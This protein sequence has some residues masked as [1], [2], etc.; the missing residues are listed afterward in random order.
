MVILY[1]ENYFKRLWCV[2][3]L[4]TLCAL[5]NSSIVDK[6]VILPVSVSC[7]FISDIKKFDVRNAEAWEPNDRIRL[8]EV[9]SALGV[10]EFNNKVRSLEKKL[11]MNESVRSMNARLNFLRN[12]V[13]SN[14]ERLMLI[15]S[16]IDKV[17]NKVDRLLSM[18]ENNS[19]GVSSDRRPF[20]REREIIL[21][22]EEKVETVDSVSG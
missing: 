18:L 5:S 15:D 14:T 4:L 9:I 3:E 22:L 1:G 20:L 17:E 19:R 7:D 11:K 2:W 21:S 13:E 12:A 8:N 16:K 10:E 6:L